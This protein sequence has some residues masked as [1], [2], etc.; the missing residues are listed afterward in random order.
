[1]PVKGLFTAIM[2]L[3]CLA[4][5]NSP[6][7]WRDTALKSYL[8]KSRGGEINVTGRAPPPRGLHLTQ[9]LGSCYKSHFQQ[10]LYVP[11]VLLQCVATLVHGLYASQV[12]KENKSR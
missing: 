8:D 4:E 12:L 11:V 1:M 6:D 2:T 7:V 10:Y 9:V 5:T 3:L